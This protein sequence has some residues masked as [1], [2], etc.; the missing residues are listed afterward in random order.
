MIAPN[1]HPPLTQAL[2]SQQRL[3]RACG[4]GD[5]VAWAAV[6]RAEGRRLLT[7]AY[8]LSGSR[9]V[10]E[11]AVTET[12]AAAARAWE[13]ADPSLPLAVWLARTCYERTERAPSAPGGRPA[14]AAAFLDPAHRDVAAG[15]VELPVELRAAVVLRCVVGFDARDA[16]RIM[17]LPRAGFEQR[18][19]QGLALLRAS[20]GDGFVE[21]EAPLPRPVGRGLPLATAD[22]LWI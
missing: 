16:A 15:L 4:M 2:A 20:P 14:D 8:W 19:R 3:A 11:G 12:F 9:E 21:H 13:R 10:A 5:P 22:T 1:S 18:L 17:D 6:V 7:L